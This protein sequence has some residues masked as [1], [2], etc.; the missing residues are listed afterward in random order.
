MKA[1]AAI[2]FLTMTSFLLT[3]AAH[4][5]EGAENAVLDEMLTAAAL[6]GLPS[7]VFCGGDHDADAGHSCT[8]CHLAFD[9]P[10][11]KSPKA[12]PLRLTNSSNLWTRHGQAQMAAMQLWRPGMARAPP[13]I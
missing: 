8:D 11:L 2:L 4:V 5:A 12:L 9:D 1:L 6:A 3:N 10:S 7:D 13:L